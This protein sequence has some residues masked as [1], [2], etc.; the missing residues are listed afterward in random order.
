MQ[1]CV[2]TI[3]HT[4]GYIN[5]NV[6]ILQNVVMQGKKLGKT[7]YVFSVDA[8][9]GKV[10]HANYVSESARSRGLDART[11]ASK[12]SDILGGKAGGKEDGAQGVGLNV[13]QVE[14]ALKIAREI[15]SS[16]YN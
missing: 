12:V 4:S 8:K 16:K 11:W 3:F 9:G 15:F 14:E 1:R 13:A 10:A 5:Y 2:A 7:V 6:Q